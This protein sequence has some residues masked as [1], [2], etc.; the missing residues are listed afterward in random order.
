MADHVGVKIQTYGTAMSEYD[1]MVLPSFTKL[2]MVESQKP[3]TDIRHGAAMANIWQ[4][5]TLMEESKIMKA[6]WNHL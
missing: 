3:A 5:W 2:V 6:I 4:H 1:A